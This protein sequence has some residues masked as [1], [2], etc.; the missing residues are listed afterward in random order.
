MV[1]YAV[2]HTHNDQ[3]FKLRKA[4]N[5]KFKP[6]VGFISIPVDE[7]Y[8]ESCYF[9]KTDYTSIITSFFRSGIHVTGGIIFEK[10][11]VFAL[12]CKEGGETVD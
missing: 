4:E 10:L 7:L 11:S 2:S 9:V 3:P 1:P 6:I 12:F 5:T 8:A